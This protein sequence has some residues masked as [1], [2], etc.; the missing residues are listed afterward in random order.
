LF[1]TKQLPD[2]SAVL[3]SVGDML[4]VQQV[5]DVT[6]VAYSATH[7]EFF[8][9]NWYVLLTNPATDVVYLYYIW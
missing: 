4:G 5:P 3:A 6:M 2:Q 7:N 8:I 1:F 9:A